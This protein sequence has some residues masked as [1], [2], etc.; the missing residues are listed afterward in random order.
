[1]SSGPTAKRRPTRQGANA[2]AA[3][4]GEAA[5]IDGPYPEVPSTGAAVKIGEVTPSTEPAERSAPDL[6]RRMKGIAAGKRDLPAGP[7]GVEKGNNTC[8]STRSIRG[9]SGPQP[10]CTT[11]VRPTEIRH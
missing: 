3:A 2:A 9:S 6:A 4:I 10:Q 1:M 11:L 8:S 7:E 5:A